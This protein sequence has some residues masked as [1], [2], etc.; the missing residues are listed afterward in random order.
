MFCVFGLLFARL[1]KEKRKLDSA[2]RYIEME[3]RY[4]GHGLQSWEKPFS[5]L[6][7]KQHVFSQVQA[8]N[9]QT[10]SALSARGIPPP[11]FLAMLGVDRFYLCPE[12]D[13]DPLLNL[14]EQL[15]PHM[16]QKWEF[17]KTADVM[18]ILRTF[19]E[20]CSIISL[21]DLKKLDDSIE[22]WRGI[23]RDILKPMGRTDLKIIID[24]EKIQKY[25]TSNR[26]GNLL[27]EIGK[28][29]SILPAIYP[30]SSKA[31]LAQ[32]ISALNSGFC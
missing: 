32:S 4:L 11:P 27:E 25:Y 30:S 29:A 1:T 24:P 28:Y 10:T 17:F 23:V 21:S 8:F 12:H 16:P 26:S 22:L 5:P 20:K 14:S 6:N 19:F 7:W 9:R 18:V 3:I 15:M 13:L 2:M 31:E